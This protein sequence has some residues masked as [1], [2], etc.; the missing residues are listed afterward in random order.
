M[1]KNDTPSSASPAE[2]LR[3][4]LA[5]EQSRPWWRRRSV[6]AGTALVLLAAGGGWLWMAKKQT[7]AAPRYVTEAARRG[8]LTLSVAAN[9]TLQPTRSIA[10]GSE[11]SGTVSKVNVDVNDRVRKGQVLVELDTRPRRRD[12]AEGSA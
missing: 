4:L 7:A 3:A 9:G 6:W 12:C 2:T 8:N 5:N 1:T 11:L 10:I